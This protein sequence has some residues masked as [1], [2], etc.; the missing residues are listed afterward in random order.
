MQNETRFRVIWAIVFAFM[1]LM[2]W[3][4][5]PS[6]FAWDEADDVSAWM[7]VDGDEDRGEEN[8]QG[9]EEALD[10]EVKKWSERST[11]YVTYTRPMLDGH[12]TSLKWS[13]EDP[14]RKGLFEPPEMKG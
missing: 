3:V 6:S 5:L 14:H 7:V 4:V 8:K 11:S 9:E 12:G 2:C 1:S 13:W 10:D